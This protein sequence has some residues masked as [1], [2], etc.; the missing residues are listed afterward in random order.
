MDT[1]AHPVPELVGDGMFIPPE[2]AKPVVQASRARVSPRPIGLLLPMLQASSII[3][4]IP[5]RTSNRPSSFALR[6]EPPGS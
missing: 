6:Q 3:S 1:L 4:I 5:H 2:E